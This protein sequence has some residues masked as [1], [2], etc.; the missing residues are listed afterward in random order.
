[1]S[2]IQLHDDFNLLLINIIIRFS[3]KIIF[4][5]NFIIHLYIVNGK[6]KKFQKSTRNHR[7]AI[8]KINYRKKPKKLKYSN[9]KQKNE[10]FENR[11]KSQKFDLSP[12]FQPPKIRKLQILINDNNFK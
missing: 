6:I 2:I 4:D 5:K 9:F 8:L 7:R 3:S 10:N 12:K 1:M 11:E